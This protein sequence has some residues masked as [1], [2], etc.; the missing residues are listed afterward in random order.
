MI[1]L[2]LSLYQN[3]VNF[4][5][6]NSFG[7]VQSY[8][9]PTPSMVRGMAHQILELTK[10][11]P[12]KISIQGNSDSVTVNM[13]K[14]MKFDRDPKSRPI[15]PYIVKVGNSVKTA[16]HGIAFVDNLINCKL[17]IH[18]AFENEELTKNLYEK[19][20][21]NTVILGRN[22]DIARVNFDETKLT[23]ISYSDD[24]NE[25]PY[26]IYVNSEDAK[27]LQLSGTS[28]RLPFRY[29]NVTSFS[30]SRIFHKVNCQFI[31]K[32]TILNEYTAETFLIDED[33]LF[34]SF[35]ET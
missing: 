3:M 25:L 30:D 6:E 17:I 7:H 35:L 12:L 27:K 31:S 32:N 1:S 16:T 23:E 2:K 9:L 10:Y 5:K 19:V 29:E 34:V 15:N 26:S 13:Q 28:F 18:I 4:R 21:K 24:E 20:M 33:G 14:V 11:N 22:E 8:P